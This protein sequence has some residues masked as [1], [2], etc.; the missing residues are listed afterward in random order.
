MKTSADTIAPRLLR[1]YIKSGRKDLPWQQNPSAYR[2]WVSEI[3]LQQTQVATVIPY[4]QRFVERFPD[5]GTL[6]AASEDEVLHHWSGLGYYSRGRNL[7]AAARRVVAEHCGKLPNDVDSW[8]ALPGVGRSTAGAILA[9]SQGK[10][11]PILDGNVKRV[12]CRYHGIGAWPGERETEKTLWTLAELHTPKRRV[13]TYTQ[14]IMDL[15]ATVCVR[16]RPRCHACPLNNDCHAFIKGRSEDIP[17][18]RPNKPRPLRGTRFLIL[19][20]PDEAVLLKRRPPSG[21]WGGLWGFPEC[22]I[23]EDPER[24]CLERFGIK[25]AGTRFL[26][27]VRHGFTHFRLEIQP[28]LLEVNGN[29]GANRIMEG[30]SALWYKG[31]STNRLGIAAPVRRILDDLPPRTQRST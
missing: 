31:A 3:M 26:A 8:R 19:R 29:A 24:V 22:R 4:F 16:R 23:E 28:V 5:V 21:V 15:G 14:A 27:P 9:L 17:A 13:A 6:A 7:H 20:D 2:V 18:P 30:G 10:R 25:P 12:L 1:W 11:H